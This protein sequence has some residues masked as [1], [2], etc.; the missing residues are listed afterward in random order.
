[1]N[2]ER[3]PINC[4]GMFNYGAVRYYDAHACDSEGRPTLMAI[5]IGYDRSWKQDPDILPRIPFGDSTAYRHFLTPNH[6]RLQV[7]TMS[8]KPGHVVLPH[9]HVPQERTP[10]PAFEILYLLTGS[11]EVTIIGTIECHTMVLRPGDWLM[12]LAG[13]HSMRAL[14]DT[15]FL[16][17]KEGPYNGRVSDKIDLPGCGGPASSI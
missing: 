17:L 16:Y 14:T 1:M 15:S 13:G 8:F 4:P 9:R 11:L 7:G 10:S 3:D 6:E 12:L 5:R 2:E